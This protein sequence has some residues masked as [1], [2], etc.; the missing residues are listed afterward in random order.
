VKYNCTEAFPLAGKAMGT[1]IVMMYQQGIV[2]SDPRN[3]ITV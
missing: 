3:E 2:H 1:R